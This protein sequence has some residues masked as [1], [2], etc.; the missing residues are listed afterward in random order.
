MVFASGGD[1]SDRHG[2]GQRLRYLPI[3]KRRLPDVERANAGRELL[4]CH[5]RQLPESAPRPWFLSQTQIASSSWP[6]VTFF[7][8]RGDG[9]LRL[10]KDDDARMDIL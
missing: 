4:A 3:G 9:H 7:G 1:R 5:P 6:W 10:V 2:N 8:L